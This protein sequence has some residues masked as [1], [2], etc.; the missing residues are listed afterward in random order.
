MESACTT[1]LHPLRLRK[2]STGCLLVSTPAS[3]YDY[4]FNACAQTMQMSSAMISSTH[5]QNMCR[6]R[7]LST[8]VCTLHALQCWPVPKTTRKIR[9]TYEHR[10]SRMYNHTYR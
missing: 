4:C 1:V 6:K 8:G 9:T 10:P 5:L 2:V 3:C 7:D